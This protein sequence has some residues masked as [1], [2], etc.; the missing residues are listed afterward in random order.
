MQLDH[1]V[2]IKSL[3][4]LNDLNFLLTLKIDRYVLFGKIT[5][6]LQLPKLN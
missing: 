6:G 3:D 1:D 2:I 5:L 4:Y